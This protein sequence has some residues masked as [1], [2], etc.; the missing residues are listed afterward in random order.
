MG[1]DCKSALSGCVKGQKYLSVSGELKIVSELPF[2]SS[3]RGVIK[4]FNEM[5]PN[6]KLIVV[7]G[8]R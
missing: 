5:F 6:V 1:T 8:A 3:C 4:Q 7:N 2:C